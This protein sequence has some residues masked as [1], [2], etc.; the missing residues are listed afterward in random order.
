M[1][2]EFMNPIEIVNAHYEKLVTSAGYS[3]R[4]FSAYLDIHPSTLSKILSGKRGI[5]KSMA[6]KFAQKLLDNQQEQK[7]FIDAVLNY[8]VSEKPNHRDE[9]LEINDYQSGDLFFIISQW[10]YFAILNILKIKNF[11]QRTDIIAKAL[12]ISTKRVGLCLNV[13]ERN[14]FV[15]IQNG[16]IK[17]TAKKLKTS[18]DIVSRALRIAHLEEL[19]L[20]KNKVEIEIVKKDYQSDVFTV[21]KNDIKKLKKL[22]EKMYQE[23]D[24]LTEK[25]NPEEVYM[26]NCQLFPISNCEFAGQVLTKEKGSAQYVH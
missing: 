8:S 26:L 24:K 9:V 21:S 11:N 5:P 3:L 6:T 18:N 19:E 12:N 25:S 20:A 17:R 23:A 16:I 4:N 13:L 14:K 15:S 1:P 7:L 10:E 22:I 2:R